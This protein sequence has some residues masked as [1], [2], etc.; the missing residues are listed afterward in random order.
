MPYPRDLRNGSILRSLSVHG[1]PKSESNGRGNVPEGDTLVGCDECERFAPGRLWSLWDMLIKFNVHELL[2]SIG[3]I[4]SFHQT[5]II[6]VGLQNNI[7]V[8]ANDHAKIEKSIRNVLRISKELDLDVLHVA[9]EDL[10]QAYLPKI[11]ISSDASVLFT[12]ADFLKIDARLSTLT[13]CT[14]H[15]FAAKSVLILSSAASKMYSPANPLFGDDVE[16]SF[17]SSSFDVSEA[18]KCLALSRYTAAVMHLMRA[19]EP[20]VSVLQKSVGVSVP[21]TQWDQVFNQIEKTLKDDAGKFTPDQRQ[22]FAE[23]TTDFRRFKNAWRNYTM[24]A[25]TTYDEERAMD[26]FYGVKSFMNHLSTKLY[27]EPA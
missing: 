16:K 10:L 4:S 17:P 23:A 19:L 22:W 12:K 6:T 11:P 13:A 7:V 8:S 3:H 26:I 2:D 20:A 21:K 5:M 27:E 14:K 24:H 25:K 15:S 18:G 1:Q 9:A